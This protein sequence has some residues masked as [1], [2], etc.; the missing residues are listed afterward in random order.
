MRRTGRCLC[1][2]ASFEAEAM[3]F[4]LEIF[5]DDKRDTYEFA[6]QTRKMTGPDFTAGFRSG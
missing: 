6:N 3:A 5:I 1:G 4:R 2:G